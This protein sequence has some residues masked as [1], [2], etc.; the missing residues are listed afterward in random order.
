[1]EALNLFDDDSTT[2]TLERIALSC[3]WLAWYCRLEARQDGALQTFYTRLRQLRNRVEIEGPSIADCLAYYLHVAPALFGYYL[4]LWEV[5]L[6]VELD[7]TVQ[8]V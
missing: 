3:A 1:M 2:E 6:T 4:L 8:N 5:V 7:P